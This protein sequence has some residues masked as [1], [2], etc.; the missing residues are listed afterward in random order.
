MAKAQPSAAA[1]D[2]VDRRILSELADNPELTN[3]ALATRLGLAESTC[4][5][6]VRAL[7]DN[8]VIVGRRLDVDASSLGYP[9]QALIKVRLGSHS[10]EH[11]ERLYD[12][13]AATPGVIQ[14]FHVAGAD[15]FYLHVAVEDAEALRDFVLHH[16]T[17]YRVVR[18]TETQLVFDRREGPGVLPRETR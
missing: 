15:D 4:A 17:V 8:G 5:Y 16:V 11:V 1:L 9:L 12:D 18:Q 7:R 10:K 6:R 13:L 14:A 3:K 2:T